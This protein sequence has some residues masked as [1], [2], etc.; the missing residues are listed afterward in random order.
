MKARRFAAAA[1]L[2]A[3][4]LFATVVFA[5]EHSAEPA[6]NPSPSA[7]QQKPEKQPAEAGKGH[8]AEASPE[9]AGETDE[10]AQFKQSESVRWIARHTGLGLQQAYW[11]S[12]LLNFAIVAVL[13]ILFLRA[14]VPGM[15]R[16]RT[17]L[18]QKGMAEAR[19]ASEDARRRLA[20]IEERLARLDA[21][22]GG[23][24]SAAEADA[25][26][27]EERIRAAA[28][29]NKR[30]VIE[31]AQQEIVAAAR[32]A[33]RELK[34]YAA[35][36]AVALAEKRIHVDAGTDQALVRSFVEQLSA[37][38]NGAPQRPGKETH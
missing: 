11:A 6:Q 23:M 24:R 37:D 28:D 22:I 25:A 15:F 26:A 27:E 5:Q 30:K 13:I 2:L 4:L 14:K 8:E 33:R 20:E 38:N 7:S 35:D 32:A 19:K 10:N 17:A 18:I 21:E 9:A 29:E 1:V 3:S 36:L 34:S 16:D 31:M 12:I